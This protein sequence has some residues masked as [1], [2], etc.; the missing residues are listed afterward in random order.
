[1][2]PIPSSLLAYVHEAQKLV[3]SQRSPRC[4]IRFSPVRP[5]FR[6]WD[7]IEKEKG[8]HPPTDRTQAHFNHWHCQQKKRTNVCNGK[9]H[10]E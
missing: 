1:M 9:S 8:R 7:I 2:N 10:Q 6:A 4:H 5:A 3:W